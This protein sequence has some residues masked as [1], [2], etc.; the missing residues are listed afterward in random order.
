MCVKDQWITEPK[1]R[2]HSR[3][4][5]WKFHNDK[6]GQWTQE[7][8]DLKSNT[9]EKKW[10]ETQRDA[11]ATKSPSWSTNSSA[12]TI[13][14]TSTFFPQKEQNFLLRVPKDILNA[15][16][17]YTYK[18]R[19]IRINF[20]S[21]YCQRVL[22]QSAFFDECH[23]DLPN[24]PGQQTMSSTIGS[25][26]PNW[27][28]T[29]QARLRRMYSRHRSSMYCS[30]SSK[31]LFLDFQ[32]DQKM[33]KKKKP[34]S[35]LAFFNPSP[36]RETSNQRTHQYPPCWQKACPTNLPP[37]TTK[38]KPDCNTQKDAHCPPRI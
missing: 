14:S 1:I 22:T 32:I 31:T 34:F 25:L 3:K 30:Y 5:F 20:N 18:E 4:T 19:H 37:E 7:T 8:I 36:I 21:T 10:E 33:E 12:W 16:F 26:F 24:A 35:I 38:R 28:F 27:I 29:H 13:E 6:D 15:T 17:T 11:A 9:K 2:L 23:I